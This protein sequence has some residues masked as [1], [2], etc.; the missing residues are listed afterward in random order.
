[1]SANF[2]T[3][4]NET[5]IDSDKIFWENISKFMSKPLGSSWIKLTG[6]QRIAL[7]FLNCPLI[8]II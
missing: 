7:S 6:F 5:S 4:E 1:M 3:S 2:K 8:G